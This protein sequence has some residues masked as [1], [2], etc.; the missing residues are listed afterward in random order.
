[1]EARRQA[2]GGLERK[3]RLRMAE[4]RVQQARTNAKIR[5]ERAKKREEQQRRTEEIMAGVQVE[6]DKNLIANMKG[7]ELNLQ[8]KWYRRLEDVDKNGERL[9]Q[10]PPCLR[11]KVPE[12][13]ALVQSL[14]LRYLMLHGDT[15]VS[16]EVVLSMEEEAG[17]VVEGDWW[18]SDD[19][20]DF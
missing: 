5:T 4:A 1:M 15:S 9:I 13:S 7:E 19:E 11:L 14:A 18:E 10:V 2:R 20:D 17:I 3:R 6:L 16:N 8:I 12:K